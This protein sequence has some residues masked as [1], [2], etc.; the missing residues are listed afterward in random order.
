MSDTRGHFHSDLQALEQNILD[1]AERCVSMTSMAME[2]V[3]K[4]D[5][6]MAERVAA[7]D[8]FVDEL[9]LSTHNRW[10]HTMARQGPMGSDLRLMSVLLH[11]NT[12]L[13]RTGDQCVNIA[14]MAQ[15]T[16]DLP[17]SERILGMLREMGDLVTPM[18]RTAV[19]SFVRRDVDEARLLPD[20]DEPIDRLNRNMYREV[21]ACGSEPELLEWATR[22]MM[23]ARALERIGD[24]AVDIGEQ[25]VFLVTGEFLEFTDDGAHQGDRV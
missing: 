18:L 4:P 23:V 17:R 7:E 24:Q 15:V 8:A 19:E 22:M 5:L 1:I 6:A 11:L 25:V 14:K 2:A 9:Y 12:T 3:L 13:E 16:R 21:V 20:M 10:I